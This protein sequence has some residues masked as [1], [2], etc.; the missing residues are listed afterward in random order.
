MQAIRY[1]RTVVEEIDQVAT[2]DAITALRQKKGLSLRKVAHAAGFSAS[3]FCDLT[4]G[5]R[6]YT[7]ETA[8]RIINAIASL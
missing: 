8:K 6:N 5:R 3:Y 4:N 1:K 7:P 2:R